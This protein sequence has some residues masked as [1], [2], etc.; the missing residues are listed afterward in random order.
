MS[1]KLLERLADQTLK[2]IQGKLFPA[3]SS[4]GENSIVTKYGEE[5]PSSVN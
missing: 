4:M 1:F 2:E 5:N 3:Q